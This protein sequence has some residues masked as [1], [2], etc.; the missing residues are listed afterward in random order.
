MLWRA[1]DKL[2]LLMCTK[3]RCGGLAGTT[4]LPRD[5]PILGA[6][7]LRDACLIAT[8]DAAGATQLTYVTSSGR[9][10]WGVPLAATSP[11]VSII[12]YGDRALAVGYSGP[13]GAEVVRFDA[14]GTATPLWSDRES[15]GA[16]ALAWSAG[17]M[18]VAHRHGNEIA[19]EV[20]A[21]LR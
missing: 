21:A 7:C 9:R 6:G 12:G 19:H 11:T 8:R 2:S 16:P 17:R 15:H 14:S 20:I 1:G 3:K 5:I 4:R 18:L 10:K 13:D